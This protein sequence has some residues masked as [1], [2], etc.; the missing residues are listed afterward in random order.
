MTKC[1]IVDDVEVTRFTT[2]NILEGIGVEPVVTKTAEEAKQA[3]RSGNFDV[4]LLDWHL[5]KESGL[6][7]IKEVREKYG[8][9]FPIVVFSGVE[10]DAQSSE[11][12]K[13]GASKFLEKPTTQDKLERCFRDL[14][15]AVG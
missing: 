7:L 15:V 11:A 5:G 14:G 12:L 13:A 9:S 8:S 1:L 3:L 6:D 2:K 10:K 4:I